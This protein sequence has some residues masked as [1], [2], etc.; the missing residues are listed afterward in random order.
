MTRTLTV[1]QLQA[2]RRG[3]GA[4]IRVS[5]K[6]QRTLDGI[7]YASKAEK[8]RAEE[9]ADLMQKGAVREV[10]RQV[11]FRLGCPENV[12]VADFVIVWAN[13]SVTVED[14]KGMRT[15]AFK[16]HAKLWSKYGRLPLHIRKSKTRQRGGVKFYE[17]VLD[18][19][20]LPPRV[21]GG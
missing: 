19:E 14:V 8:V 16:K 2:I 7:V 9:L 15:E 3:R 13:E 5:P 17:T 6:E 12:Y 10:M 1:E 20:I 11:K 21:G 4:R 18:E